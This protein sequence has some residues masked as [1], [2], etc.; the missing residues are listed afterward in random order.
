MKIFIVNT[1]SYPLFRTI[2]RWHDFC[3][4][5]KKYKRDLLCVQSNNFFNLRAFLD[6]KLIYE[7]IHIP[8]M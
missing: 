2:G 3:T 8:F 1:S 5:G 7:T 6:I 4:K